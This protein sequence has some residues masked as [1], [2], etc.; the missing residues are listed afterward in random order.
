MRAQL[1]NSPHLSLEHAQLRRTRAAASSSASSSSSSA[2]AAASAA[3]ARACGRWHAAHPAAPIAAAIGEGGAADAHPWRR[4]PHGRATDGRVEGNGPQGGGRA[5]SGL[6]LEQ[7]DLLVADLWQPSRDDLSLEPLT[8]QAEGQVVMHHQLELHLEGAPIASLV[9]APA[10]GTT[11]GTAIGTAAAV[12]AA[13][14]HPG[15]AIGRGCAAAVAGAC[16]GPPVEAG[17]QRRRGGGGGGGAVGGSGG[18]IGGVGGREV[19]ERAAAGAR[20]LDRDGERAGLAAPRGVVRDH[21]ASLAARADELVDQPKQQPYLGL[22]AA[23]RRHAAG[24]A[25][26]CIDLRLRAPRGERLLRGG[27]VL[28]SEPLQRVEGTLKQLLP[29]DTQVEVVGG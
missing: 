14:V 18:A 12:G 27:C 17:V 19:C 21:L 15:G 24:L 25:V 28:R 8:K 11:A 26:L 9:S 3:A 6:V 20:V 22:H 10:A 16:S 23:G 2:A 13:P 4:E 7:H 29:D 5:A 1:A